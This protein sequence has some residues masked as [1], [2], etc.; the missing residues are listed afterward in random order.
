MVLRQINANFNFPLNG[1]VKIDV[2]MVQMM[3]YMKT[4]KILKK[5]E[6]WPNM[7]LFRFTYTSH[8]SNFS[9]FR[10]SPELRNDNF[11]GNR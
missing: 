7:F 10:E 6:K 2:Y 5:V 8:R 9:V 11:S 1:I 3:V 4:V